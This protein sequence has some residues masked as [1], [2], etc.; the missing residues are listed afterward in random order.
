VILATL[1]TYLKQLQRFMREQ[2][3]DM[4]TPDALIDYV[5]RA[6]RE[7]AERTQC[8]RRITPISGSVMSATVTAHGSGYTAPIVTITAPDFPSGFGPNPGGLQATANAIVQSGTIAAVDILAG[9]SGY[10]QPVASVTDSTGSG[11][12]VSLTV[13]PINQLNPNQEVYKF[14]DINVSM[15]PGVDSVY[16]IRGVSVIYAN[17]RY[18]LPQ[19][20]FSEYQAKI[21]QYPFSY[22]YVPAFFSQFGQGTDGSLYVYPLPSQVYQIEYDCQCV[23]SELVDDQSVDVIPY[24][25]SDVVAYFAAH[26]GY[27]DL[28]NLNGAQW[29]LDL[30]DKMTLRKSQYARI[31]KVVN[32]YGRYVLPFTLEAIAA[33]Q[34]LLHS[35]LL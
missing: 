2:H 32:P 25:W 22:V 12:A 29:Y 10:F 3:Q 24:P 23:P 18:S 21:R 28:Q 7:V 11:A 20:S 5:N 17:Y 6:R 34:Q 15:F 35:G 33:L 1:N 13:S 27:M 31:G 16:A 19:Y 8:V 14:F 26:L 4:I 9:G 30:F